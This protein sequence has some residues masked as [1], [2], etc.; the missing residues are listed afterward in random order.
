MAS[1]PTLVFEIKEYMV[2]F[3]QLEEREF[4]GTNAQIRGLVR[5]SGTPANSSDECRLDVYFLADTSDF[6]SP[7]IDLANRRG[8]LFMPIAEMN[9]FVDIL[10]NEKPIYGHLRSDRPEWT[11]ITTA[12]EP[13]GVGDEDD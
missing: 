6:P 1:M 9:F 5:C 13:V 10:R 2:I 4:G 7:Q 11:S 8:E 12:K 3:R